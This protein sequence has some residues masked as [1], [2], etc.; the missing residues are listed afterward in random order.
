[1]NNHD[2]A[3]SVICIATGIALACLKWKKPKHECV[4]SDDDYWLETEY[5][6]ID[7]EMKGGS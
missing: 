4:P 3:V 7:H 1:M 2:I 6:V 5:L